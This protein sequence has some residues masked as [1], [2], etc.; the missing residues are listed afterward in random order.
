MRAY[1]NTGNNNTGDWN[2]GDRNTGLF[3]TVKAK[4]TYVFN[5]LVDIEIAEEIKRS[6]GYRL[7]T[8]IVASTYSTKNPYNVNMKY[9]WNQ[10]SMA[11]RIKVVMIS[12]FD[13]NVFYEIT[14]IKTDNYYR[15][16]QKKTK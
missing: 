10:L 7:F 6:E 14:G 12:Y 1:S 8:R 2:A 16:V 4:K 15:Y 3:N 9:A 11:E 13:P 5:K